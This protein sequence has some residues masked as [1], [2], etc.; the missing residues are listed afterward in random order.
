MDRRKLAMEAQMP[1][2][3]FNDSGTCLGQVR[4]ML[5]AIRAQLR[6]EGSIKG[7]VTISLLVTCDA[8]ETERETVN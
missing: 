5:G 3:T 1:A 2:V 6:D 8:E 4:Q 7:Q